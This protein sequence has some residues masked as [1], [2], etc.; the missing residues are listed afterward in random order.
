MGWVRG[1]KLD[2]GL[3]IIS[4]FFLRINFADH[5]LASHD[6]L[7]WNWIMSSLTY[8]LKLKLSFPAEKMLFDLIRRASDYTKSDSDC[9]S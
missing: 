4:Y 1:K 5:F 6:L 8:R 3:Q 7:S 2:S 9:G